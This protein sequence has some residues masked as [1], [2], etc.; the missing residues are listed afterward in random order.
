M[1]ILYVENDPTDA[2]LTRR[3][4]QKSAP[5]YRLEIVSTAQE[6]LSRL[7]TLLYDIAL[8]DVHLTDGD[9]L[10]LLTHIRRRAWPMPV[11]MVT[12]AGNEE[13]A[14]AALKAGADDYIVK[15]RDY[16]ERLPG[17]LDN[18]LHRHRAEATRPPQ[19]L[20]VLYVEHNA[21][22]VDLTQRHFTAHAPYIRIDTIPTIE[23][24]LIRFPAGR[25]PTIYDVILLDYHMPGH[26]GLEA[27]QELRQARGVETP[28]V[29]VTGHG[30]E[31]LAMHAL[32][33]GAS[34]YVPKAPG[35]LFK[36]PA[37]IENAHHRA[38]AE[39]EHAALEASEAR[40]RRL[41]E[42]AAD[43]IYRYRF[44]PTPSFE[45]VNPAVT[46]ITGY[47]PEELY[48]NPALGEGIVH[49]ADRHLVET[50][51]PDA[52]LA[53][54]WRRK[55]GALIWTE[56]R[57]VLIR[58]E[59]GRIVAVEG[60]V[61]DITARKQ[62]E[63]S[64]HL[65]NAALQ[66]AANAIV[67]TDGSGA[68]EWANPAFTELSGYTLAE[69]VGK[70]PRDLVRSGAHDRAFYQ[71]LWDTILSGETWRG[72]II[73][74]HKDGA[75]YAEELAITPVRD[76]RGN[77]QHFVAIKQDISERAERQR[78]ME[79]IVVLS[80]AL[81]VAQTRSEMLPI[82]LDQLRGLFRASG[83]SMAVRDPLTHETLIEL[84][85]GEWAAHTGLRLPAGEAISEQVIT[86]GQ[87]FVSDD[88]RGEGRIVHAEMLGQANALM[89]IPLIAQE[90]A[91]GALWL[92]RAHPFT[93]N[94]QRL[95]TALVDIAANALRRAT[96]HEQTE[97]QLQRLTA[98]RTIDAAITASVDARVTL[99]I[100]LDQVTAQLRVDAA[101]VLL[102]QPHL[103]M[104]KYAAG[105][106]FRASPLGRASPRIGEGHA[107]RAALERRI[108][109][110]PDLT[111]DPGGWA[112]EG[113]V[114]YYGVPLIAQGQVKG[115]LEIFHRAPLTV[116]AEWLEFLESLA[117]QAAIAVD[118]AQLFNDL[119]RSHDELALA[120]DATI[121]GWARALD[122]R[123]QETDGHTRR[124]TEMTL[125]LARRLGLSDAELVHL[126]RGALLHDIGQ[127]GVPDAIRSK[128]GPLTEAEWAS[129]RQHPTLA[130]DMLAPIAFLRPAL[131]IPHGHHERWDGA[132]YPRGLKGEQ[133][134]LAARL[135]AVV[136]VWDALR[137][138]RPYRARWPD[139]QV[140]EY[141]RAQAGAHFD[142]AI[143]AAFLQ[144]WEASPNAK[145]SG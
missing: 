127:M 91:I 112:G 73:N 40:F 43:I 126:R 145:A 35:Y 82:L 140:R 48:A 23:Q 103:Q 60:V 2:D 108:V 88:A 57:N 139:E 50:S 15:S 116:D 44:L 9:G 110:V 99:N 101:D 45:Y 134:P 85:R 38:L 42:N 4:L 13:L 26:N 32:R 118:N 123:D 62:A 31:E 21:L 69:A 11:V 3:A 58:D 22:D 131:D 52:V 1:R 71:R 106:G 130:H 65:Q 39:R 16:L 51:A 128:P 33:L 66:A 41:A 132:G 120:Y 20:R 63:A 19:L 46:V 125:R 114:A 76:E 124:V 86:T 83:A 55:D 14:V 72:E 67:I 56:Q 28:V 24:L 27:L 115:V 133:I 97:R 89:C 80:T 141:L 74:R 94:E 79:A 36:L 77:I 78:E 87:L 100:L 105:R 144:L 95:F 98:L 142:P 93:V 117:G 25:A 12:G 104:L 8:L 143:V 10:A 113:F 81:R 121:E 84:G 137:S 138:D 70:N 109:C 119:Q 64:L 96:L 102:F 7:E 6:A 29:L 68:I 54:R 111:R 37:I 92:G 53:L 107:G 122:L 5:N 90:Q 59:A 30:T 47:T 75:L 129:M 18:T 136:D 17:V 49:P 34:D 135:F 61:R